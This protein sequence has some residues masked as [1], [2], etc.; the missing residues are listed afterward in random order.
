MLSLLLC[1]IHAFS[2]GA[3]AQALAFAARRLAADPVGVVFAA[4]EPGPERA[5]LRPRCGLY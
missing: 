3:S 5:G 4:R 1:M 2:P